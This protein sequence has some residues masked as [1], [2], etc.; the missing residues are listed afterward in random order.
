V[1]DLL[2]VH[3]LPPGPY[4]LEVSSPGLDRPLT[5]DKDFERYRGSR[6]RI[7]S[8]EPIDGSRN[9][10]G[11]LAEV[12]TI[13]G[14]KAVVVDVDGRSVRIDRDNIQK[15]NLEHEGQATGIQP[16]ASGKGKRK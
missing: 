7:R 15:A 1:G 8:R 14:R 6:V 2:N 13:D 3:D 5:R 11:T 12:M 9:F 4:T 16:R 10:L